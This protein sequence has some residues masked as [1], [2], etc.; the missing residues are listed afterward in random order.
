LTTFIEKHFKK[1]VIL[2]LLI[3]CL[4]L[5]A[6][7]NNGRYM[8]CP[9]AGEH[10]VVHVLDTKTSELWT[11]TP[12]II[13]YWGTNNKLQNKP[14]LREKIPKDVELLKME[15]YWEQDKK[16]ETEGWKQKDSLS[17]DRKDHFEEWNKQL[18]NSKDKDLNQ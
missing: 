12:R 10:Y 1:L 4:L 9:D 6:R 18:E 5:Y 11:R 8:L 14:I 16:V 7:R 2:L 3:L 15:T 17:K 13:I